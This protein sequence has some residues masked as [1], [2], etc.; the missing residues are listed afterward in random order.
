MDVHSAF[1]LGNRQ[2]TKIRPLKVIM[3]RKQRKDVIDNAK[4]IG[5]K[6]PY[7][8]R[9]VVIVKDLTSRQ[10]EENKQRRI[11]KQQRNK[12]KSPAKINNEVQV[13]TNSSPMD[14]EGSSHRNAYSEETVL[15][16]IVNNE[17]TIIGGFSQD[18]DAAKLRALY[19]TEK[20][21]SP[22]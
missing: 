2:P 1:R 22:V 5:T 14:Q 10:R 21:E 7:P 12:Q 11:N 3:M 17:E 6:A 4:F 15:N 16:T 8:F 19:P 20:G 13:H 18:V 9:K